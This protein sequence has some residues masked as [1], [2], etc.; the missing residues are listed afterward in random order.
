MNKTLRL[1]AAPGRDAESETPETA[2]T[3]VKMRRALGLPVGPR[4]A[5]DRGA[6]R[7]AAVAA[8]TGNRTAN[9]KDLQDRLEQESRNAAQ[10]KRELET[11]RQTISSLETRV[12][13][14]TIAREEERAKFEAEQKAR[15]EAEE[16][17]AGLA[18]APAAPPP[19]PA[20]L[21]ADAS[22]P[23]RRGRPPGRRNNPAPA[24]AAAQ[25]DSSP[26]EWWVPGWR[27]R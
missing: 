10:Y 17:L 2:E 8:A 7:P 20:T 4:S 14:L 9:L 12:H 16:K 27:E 15:I 5:A 23:R 3:E 1:G 13:H 24:P 19:R 18:S 6:G 21:A 26:V 22:A 25:E 11:A